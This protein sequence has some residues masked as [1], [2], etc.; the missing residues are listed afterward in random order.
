GFAEALPYGDGSFDRVFSSM[1]FHHLGRDERSKVLSEVRR[2][3][4]PGGRLEFLDLAGGTHNL[5][6]L[7]LHCRQPH[8]TT[9]DRAP[10]PHEP[11]ARGRTVRGATPLHAAHACR[12]DRVL[13]GVG[14]GRVSPGRIYAHT[15][16]FFAQLESLYRSAKACAVAFSAPAS[17]VAR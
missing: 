4:K 6:A 3:L 13:P 14:A 2:V 15:D 10:R 8:A 16:A 12:S 7:I 11:D 17:L 1:M 9:E 5:L